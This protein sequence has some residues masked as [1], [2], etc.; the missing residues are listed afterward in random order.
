MQRYKM[1]IKELYKSRDSS[2]VED[3]T[4]GAL[5]ISERVVS[6]E[7][8]DQS[9]AAVSISIDPVALI[10]TECITITSA[11]RKDVR[12]ARSS[13]STILGGGGPYRAGLRSDYIK[14]KEKGE[15]IRTNGTACN[16][17]YIGN[18]DND[19]TSYWGRKGKKATALQDNPLQSAFARLRSDLRG[20]TG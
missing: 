3:G 2:T 14:E 20:C 9:Y 11:M 18:N 16:D 4:K 17:L 12:L 13:V 7:T 5:E 19:S 6:P 15:G 8:L 10:S 1:T